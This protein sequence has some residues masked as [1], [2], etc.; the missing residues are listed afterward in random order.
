MGR[1]NGEVVTVACVRRAWLALPD[2][3]T[4]GLEG[5]GYFCS[6]LDLGYPAVREVTNPRPM[7]SGTDDT[8]LFYGARAITAAVTALAGAGAVI[9]EVVTMFGPFVSLAARPDLHYVLDRPGAPERII[10]GLRVANYSAPIEGAYERDLQLQWVAPDPFA[11]GAAQHSATSWAGTGVLGRVYNLVPNRAYP[12]GAGLP[13]AGVISSDGDVPVKPYVRIFGPITNPRV[14]FDTNGP[15]SVHSELGLDMR[16]DAG[17]FVGIDTVA[18]HAYLDDDVT[19]SV[20]PELAWPT[21][22][23]PVLPPLPDATTFA[24]T[25]TGTTSASQ[26]V[27]SW[28]DGYLT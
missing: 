12:V 26:A 3:R 24:L 6:S 2:G 11:R 9:D 8:S 4:I 20:L 28:Y 17:H 15:P 19:Q 21:L 10:A 7:Q 23:W 13:S 27:A 18:H 25:G 5:T 1:A 14:T 16:V 22:T